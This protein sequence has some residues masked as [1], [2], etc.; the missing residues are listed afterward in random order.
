MLHIDMVNFPLHS[1]GTSQLPLHPAIPTLH[2]AIPTVWRVVVPLMNLQ[3]ESYV[4]SLCSIFSLKALYSCRERC[5]LP[6]F[7]PFILLVNYFLVCTF[8]LLL[9]VGV[10][11]PTV[12]P[13]V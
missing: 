9:D 1:E 4:V 6:L 2:P 5:P 12:W 13:A 3:K 10:L 8:Y 11:L 7:G